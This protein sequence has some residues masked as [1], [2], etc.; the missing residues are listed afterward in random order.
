[1]SL[2]ARGG[3]EAVGGAW[4]PVEVDTLCIHGDSPYAPAAARQVRAALD[5]AG[6]ALAP[7]V[8]DPRHR[9]VG[10]RSEQ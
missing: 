1:V 8:P 2:V 10:R 5:A 3:T 7:F 9:P 6:I 4:T